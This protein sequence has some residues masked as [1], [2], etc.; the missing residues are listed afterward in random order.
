M[1]KQDFTNQ[2]HGVVVCENHP[3]LRWMSKPPSI[4]PLGSRSIF[5]TGWDHEVKIERLYLIERGAPEA[6]SY[7]DRHEALDVLMANSADAYGFPPYSQLAPHLALWADGYQD[8]LRAERRILYS[9][10]QSVSVSR[11]RSPVSRLIASART[12]FEETQGG[13]RAGRYD[14]ASRNLMVDGL[15][16]RFLEDIDAVE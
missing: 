15:L 3:H 9:A 2:S 4:A 1:T 8:L 14:A 5:F 13:Y 10:L 7:P 12:K 11:L 6:A 16:K